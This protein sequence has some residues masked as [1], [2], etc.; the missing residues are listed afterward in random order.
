MTTAI[1]TANELDQLRAENA[2]LRAQLDD[3]R[4][5]YLRRTDQLLNAL[6][7]LQ[8]M[9]AAAYGRKTQVNHV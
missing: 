7:A 8:K 6:D 1:T 9:Q 3:F 5:G 4:A 2:E